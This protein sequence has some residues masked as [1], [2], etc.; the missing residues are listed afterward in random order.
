[1]HLRSARERLYQTLLFEV[2]GLFMVI[3][4]YSAV[5]TAPA[6][7]A[8]LLIV[9]I[10]IAVMT[11]SPIHNTIFDI[12]ELRRTGRVASDRPTNLRILH[13]L[14]HEVTS[15]ILTLPLMIFL[16]GHNLVDALLVDMALTAF[17][18]SYASISPLALW[19]WNV[20]INSVNRPAAIASRRP[21]I[22]S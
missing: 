9:A 10:S 16:G 11:W 14:S 2:G 7:E 1:M 12:V 21:C 17:Y 15:L 22:R 5:F 20:A 4:I 8:I 3:P 19:V 18:T 13:A 6:Q